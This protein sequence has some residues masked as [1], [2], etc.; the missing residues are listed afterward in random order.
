M[1]TCFAVLGTLDLN[2]VDGLAKR[3]LGSICVD[4]VFLIHITRGFCDL[5]KLNKRDCHCC[6]S[7]LIAS[8]YFIT[9]LKKTRGGEKKGEKIPFNVL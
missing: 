4:F 9:K 5:R 8:D 3:N 6:V 1:T 7:K 2:M